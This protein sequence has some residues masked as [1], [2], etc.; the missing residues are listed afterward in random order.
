[1]E[2]VKKG[3][4]G[5][6]IMICGKGGTGKS[7]ISVLMAR[8]LSRKYNVYLIDS[9]ESNTLLPEMLG[10]PQ[11]KPLVEY[12][13][14]RGSV[15]KRGEVNI[16]RALSKAGRGVVLKNLPGQYVSRS[17]EGIGLIVIGK[18]RNYSEG[19]ACPLNYLTRTLLKHLVLDED[20]V[21]LVDTDAGIEHIGRGVEE[22]SD[23]VLA[24]VDPTAESLSLAKTLKEQIKP[25][26]KKFWLVLNKATP[27]V[28]DIIIE[29]AKGMGLEVNGVIGFD[30]K[31]FKSCLEGGVLKAERSMSQVENVLKAINLL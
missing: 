29:K 7:V 21:V 26:K 11:P 2:I 4:R 10:A 20:E 22:G 30:E 23:A 14:G 31:I 24:V 5:L 6:K 28:A 3:V 18:V 25:L 15:F 1:M 13:G 9:D 19:C 16:V 17:P 8:I 27:E 12:L